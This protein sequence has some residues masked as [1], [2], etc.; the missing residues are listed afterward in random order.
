MRITRGARACRSGAMK[1]AVFHGGGRPLTIEDVPEPVP[2]PGEILVRVAA[3]GV[4]HTDLHYL[5]HGTPTFHP[6]PLILGHEISGTV[7][8]L[9]PGADGVAPGD[10]VLLPAV[11]TCGACTMCRTGRENICER[12]VMLGNHVHGGYAELVVAPAKDVHRLPGSLPLEESAIIA[13][14]LTTPYHAVVHR[15]GVTPGDW[16]VVIGCGGIGLNL[17]QVAAMTGGRVIAVDLSD[18]KLERACAL[19]AEHTLNPR[20]ATRLDKEIRAL[21]GGAG[22]DIALEAVG[23]AATQEQALAALRTGGRLVLVG[24]SPETLPL[25]A[26]RVMFRELEVVG[27]LGCRPV[28][29]ARVI[30]LAANGK[31]RVAALVSHRFPL[32]RIA[33]AF[34]ALRSGAAIRAIVVP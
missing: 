27:S 33:D 28:D 17:V 5:D 11:L 3:C 12:S 20:R 8:A 31:L 22:A 16:V 23:K 15:A 24:Y 29:Y 34:D 21:T 18:E 13:D 30:A 6:P 26:G 2:K 19:G 10:R 7:V 4:C 14:A 25:N 9:G 1:A 32:D